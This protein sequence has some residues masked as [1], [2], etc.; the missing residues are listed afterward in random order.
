M[1]AASNPA[2]TKL[3]LCAGRFRESWASA[4]PAAGAA[5]QAPKSTCLYRDVVV[6]MRACSSGASSPATA[7]T[8]TSAACALPLRRA[9]MMTPIQARAQT[10]PAHSHESLSTSTGEF[11][12]AARASVVYMTPAT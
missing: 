4:Y 10:V 11:S 6:W 12:P 8:V 2:V 5:S 9:D 1:A 3:R 7:K